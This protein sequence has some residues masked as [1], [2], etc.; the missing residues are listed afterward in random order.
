MNLTSLPVSEPIPDA[1]I[2]KLIIEPICAAEFVP[3]ESSSWLDL[4]S[5]GGSPAIPLRLLHGSGKLTMVEARERKCA[6][7]R[8]VVRT[9]ELPRTFVAAVRFEGFTASEPADLI[10][11]RAV[12]IDGDTLDRICRW[13]SQVAVLLCFGGSIDDARFSSVA[14][15]ALPDGSVLRVFQRLG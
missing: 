4:G 6:F 10:T 14:S 7:L 11:L 2:D 9:L 1:S 8:E 12:R 3:D 5:G 15:R 13:S